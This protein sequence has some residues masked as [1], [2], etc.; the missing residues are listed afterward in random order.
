M[1][2]ESVR[3]RWQYTTLNGSDD[4]GT[5]RGKRS[6]IAAKRRGPK[7]L[8]HRE[9]TRRY[10]PARGRSTRAGKDSICDIS[11]VHYVDY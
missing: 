7:I 2:P 9:R 10:Q 4:G 5:Y 6:A 8:D 3:I 1:D 11:F